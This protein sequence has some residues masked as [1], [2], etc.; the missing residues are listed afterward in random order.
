MAQSQPRTL[1]ALVIIW[2][3]LACQAQDPPTGALDMMVPDLVPPS[4]DG[5]VGCESV[6]PVTIALDQV[7][8]PSCSVTQP[9]RGKALGA[10]YVVVKGAQGWSPPAKV[11]LDG[12]FC[13]EVQLTADSSNSLTFTPVD[14]AGCEG[15]GLVQTIQHSSSCSAGPSGSSSAGPSTNVAQ[16]TSVIVSA[17]PD[18]GKDLYLVD[19]KL[20]TVVRYK[21]GWGPT[22]ADIQIDL[23]L[24][25]AYQVE[26]IIVRWQDSKGNG[27]DYAA[28]Y[29]VATSV[30]P[31]P[32]KVGEG[33]WTTAAAVTDGDGGEDRFDLTAQPAVQHV[34]LK[35][36]YDGCTSWSESFTL[37]EIEVW[38]K[39]P[40]AAA[41]SVARCGQ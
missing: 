7:T 24:S 41:P 21:A 4:L 17:S 6:V 28:A 8:S 30:Q 9:F 10:D 2:S 31:S 40:V 19:G 38:A 23:A 26:V 5:A 13:V 3:G 35:L 15:Q 1:L 16:G 12:S 34:G 14:R 22:S 18:S 11:N 39:D 36:R 29:D 25:K 20:G 33:G 27:C 32:G 37:R